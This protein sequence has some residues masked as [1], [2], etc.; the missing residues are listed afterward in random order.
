[1]LSRFPQLFS[2]QASAR[3]L[4]IASALSILAIAAACSDDSS[5]TTP[6]GGLARV[7]G[8]AIAIGNGSARTYIVID[9]KHGDA[10]LEI[11]VALDEAALEGLPQDAGTMTMLDLPLPSQNPTPY[12][13]V[14]LDWNPHGHEPEGVYSVPHF[15]FHFYTIAAAVRNAIDPTDTSFQ[16]KANTL[17]AQG[18]SS[19]FYVPL[20]P[21]QGPVLAIPRMG[22][23]WAD[24]RAPELQGAFG[25]PENAKP[26]TT[27]FLHGSWNGQFIFDEPMVTRAFILARK[28]ATANAARDSI[29]AVS[30]A[31]SYNPAGYRPAAY[32]V[33]Y[34]AQKHEYQIALT[35][36]TAHP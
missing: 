25:H 12:R 36:L 28:E 6:N 15:D 3:N 4:A 34:D 7:N 26:F 30:S 2:Q 21:P 10:P 27:T 18:E 32:R 35:Q 1:M 23:H 16:T 19:Q 8:Q 5:P 22:V 29:V 13:L 24:M 9:K 17:P 14:E 31:Q 33:G 11:G 20:S